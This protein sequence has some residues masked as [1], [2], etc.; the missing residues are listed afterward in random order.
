VGEPPLYWQDRFPGPVC[1]LGGCQ[2]RQQQT[3]DIEEVAWKQR[4]WFFDVL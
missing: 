4:F 3:L 2:S 1:L